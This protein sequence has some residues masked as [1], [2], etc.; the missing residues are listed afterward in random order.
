MTLRAAGQNGL[1][2][3]ADVNIR[4]LLALSGL[5][6]GFGLSTGGVIRLKLA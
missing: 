4:L 6:V 3:D 2:F 1:L 5:Q